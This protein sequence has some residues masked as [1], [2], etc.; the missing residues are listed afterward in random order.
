MYMG[1]GLT[2]E[3]RTCD[4]YIFSDNIFLDLFKL[5]P[6]NKGGGLPMEIEHNFSALDFL[7][8]HYLQG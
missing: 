1:L 5:K 4:L 7:K 8:L 6:S 3:A 2:T